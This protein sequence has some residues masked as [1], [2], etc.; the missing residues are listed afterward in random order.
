MKDDFEEFVIIHAQGEGVDCHEDPVCLVAEFWKCQHSN[1]ARNPVVR[2]HPGWKFA[3]CQ[4]EDRLDQV[5][6][7][8]R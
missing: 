3:C 5:D 2:F 1:P 4:Q 8:R 7:K 6:F